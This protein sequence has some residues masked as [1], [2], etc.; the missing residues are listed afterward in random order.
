MGHFRPKFADPHNSG[1]TERMFLKFYTMRGFY[2]KGLIDKNDIKNFLKK[3]LF[4]ERGPS[5]AQNE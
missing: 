5:W 4:G 1:S 3:N 2:T